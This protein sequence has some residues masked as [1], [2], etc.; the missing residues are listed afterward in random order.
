LIRWEQEA[1]LRE[2]VFSSPEDLWEGSKG[3]EK[4]KLDA[5]SGFRGFADLSGDACF[6][7]ETLF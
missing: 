2:V 6:V 3:S 7:F 5:M 4:S 1:G